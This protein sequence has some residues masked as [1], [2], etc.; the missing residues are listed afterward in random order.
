[1]HGSARN[2]PSRYRS[3]LVLSLLVAL[4]TAIYRSIDNLI[5]HN[6]ITAEDALTA[7]FAYLMVGGWVGVVLGT[8]FSL[9]LGK[10]LIDPD[11]NRIVWN[12]RQMHRKAMIC[13]SISA[14]S[15]LFILLGTQLGDPTALVALSTATLLY[16]AIYEAATKQINFKII[17]LPV[18]LGMA[19]A[20]L[21]AWNGSL[22]VTVWG[23]LM[24]LIVSNGLGA[25]S[26]VIEKKGVQAS[27]GVNFFIWRFVW[28]AAT[29]TILALACSFLR[30]TTGLLVE[31]LD[32]AISAIP[33][34]LL[35]MTAVFFGMGLKLT[36]KKKN[37]VS[38]VLLVSSVQVILA[39][40]ITLVGEWISPG[41]FGS[42]T[43][44]GSIW[45]VRLLGAAFLIWGI[46]LLPNISSRTEEIPMPL[47]KAAE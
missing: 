39:F 37:A 12:N 7:A 46:A 44:G 25:F 32:L 24:V 13:G 3:F 40:P 35:T 22:S 10:R 34:I 9:F 26:E 23:V 31:T 20:C 8:I 38:L 43:V 16:V 30:G 4:C 1:M 28:L 15:T 21:A 19:G 6:F 41:I 14:G 18:V 5:V 27:D 42:A 47:K 2:S 17:A 33:I 36:L 29:G 11:F 45:A